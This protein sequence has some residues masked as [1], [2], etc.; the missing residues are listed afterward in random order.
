M[1]WVGRTKKRW[2][3]KEAKTPMKRRGHRVYGNC[4]EPRC[5]W[6]AMNRLHSRIKVE[7]SAGLDEREACHGEE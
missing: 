2:R 7:M 1:R 5:D 6:C 4:P 3:W